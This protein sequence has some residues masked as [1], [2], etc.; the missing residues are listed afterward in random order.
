[1]LKNNIVHEFCYHC[2]YIGLN[3][4]DV[5]EGRKYKGRKLLQVTIKY[6]EYYFKT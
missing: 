4:E 2:R 3:L 1:M 5:V 6:R